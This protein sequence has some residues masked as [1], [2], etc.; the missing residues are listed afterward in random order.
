[1]GRVFVRVLR[2]KRWKK[3]KK[4]E[5]ERERGEPPGSRRRSVKRKREIEPG[6]KRGNGVRKARGM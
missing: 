1:M 2:E 5:R 3:D 4:K 6:R